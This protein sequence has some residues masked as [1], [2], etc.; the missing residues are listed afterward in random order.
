MSIGVAHVAWFGA[1][2]SRGPNLV[3]SEGHGTVFDE[4]DEWGSNVQ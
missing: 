2:Y 4:L 3:D 1:W